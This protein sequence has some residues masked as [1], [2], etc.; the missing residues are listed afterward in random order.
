MNLLD[1]KEVAQKLSIHP[2][3]VYTLKDEEPTFP[4][5]VRLS[6]KRVRWVEAEVDDW[7]KTKKGDANDHRDCGKET[8]S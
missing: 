4:S 7:I 3:S 8:L 1:Y 2:R 5:P 6:N